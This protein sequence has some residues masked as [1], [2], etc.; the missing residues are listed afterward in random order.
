MTWTLVL[1]AA[2]A[3]QSGCTEIEEEQIL[4]RH[5][6][7]AQPA[8]AAFDG[9]GMVAFTPAPG[10]RRRFPP[11]ELARLALRR[12][13]AIP[14]GT[15]LTGICFER[16]TAALTAG[17]VLA[18]LRA[19]LT[20]ASTQ[21]ELIDFCRIPLPKGRL[22]FKR[23]GLAL[24]PGGSAR[25]PVVW[26][27]GLRYSPA[28]SVPV[29]AKVKVWVRRERVVANEALAAGA[30]IEARQLRLEQ[31][32]APPFAAAAAARIEDVTGR[33]LRRSVP[34]DR[35]VPA[36]LLSAP[37]DVERGQTVAVEVQSGSAHLKFQAK[38]ESGGC[39]GDAILVRNPENN[40]RF[41]ARISGKGT[42][43]VDDAGAG[44]GGGTQ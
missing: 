39:A 31:I 2:A 32:E 16:P 42:V 12:G 38:A 34:A 22:E 30:I 18:A 1:A 35:P 9:S 20:E 40:R 4:G 26:R 24:P 5:I 27:G 33:I 11:A 41:R 13:I 21:L 28:H 6:A 19:A 37:N 7:A 10:V 29:W 3:L 43:V 8:L 44:A 23:S 15:A 14:E 25:L 17:S 36:T